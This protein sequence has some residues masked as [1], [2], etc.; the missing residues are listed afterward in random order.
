MQIQYGGRRGFICDND[1]D[2]ID[3]RVACAEFGLHGI[4]VDTSPEG[5]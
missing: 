2:G 1:W 3:A 5:E 4:D